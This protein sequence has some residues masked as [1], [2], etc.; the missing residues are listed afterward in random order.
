M[1]PKVISQLVTFIL[2]FIPFSVVASSVTTYF[3]MSDGDTKLY[4]FTLEGITHST[5]LIYEYLASENMFL[6][7]DKIDNSQTTYVDYSNTLDT[8]GIIYEGEYLWFDQPLVVVAATTLQSGGKITSLTT[9][10]F[11]EMEMSIT[12][13]TIV[14]KI[15][16]V[17]VPAGRFDDC[18]SISFNVTI[19]IKG[20]TYPV[21]LHQAWTLAPNVGKIQVKVTDPYGNYLTTA[22]LVSGQVSGKDVSEYAVQEKNKVLFSGIQ[23]LLLG[24]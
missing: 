9:A 13:E 20:E 7:S 5:E 10:S 17:V 6:E 18:R 19:N 2:F 3:P 12:S 1:K 22:N 4:T 15:G 11:R 16:T 21:V 23:L 8:W 14:S 24:K